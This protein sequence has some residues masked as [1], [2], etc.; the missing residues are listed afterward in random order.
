[1]RRYI[2]G[3]SRDTFG[4]KEQE[5]FAAGMANILNVSPEHVTVTAR[6]CSLTPPG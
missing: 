5:A 6:W 2:Q 3:Y 4:D 1:L